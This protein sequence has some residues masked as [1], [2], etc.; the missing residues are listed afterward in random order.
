MGKDKNKM[1]RWMIV[2]CVLGVL[3]IAGAVAYILI[4]RSIAGSLQSDATANAQ[5]LDSAGE[6][7]WVKSLTAKYE[8]NDFVFVILPGSDDAT[9]EVDKVVKSASEQIEQGGT[10][11]EVMTLNRTDPELSLTSERLA[12]QKLPAVLICSATGQ[13]AILK[14]D[15]TGEK[16]MQA[17]LTLQKA[18]VPGVSGCCPK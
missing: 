7:N 10:N 17:Y 11:V 2:L 12:I 15:V 4:T 13:R 6:M 3:M 5:A 8:T 18:C 1:Q 9:A 14:G 16:L